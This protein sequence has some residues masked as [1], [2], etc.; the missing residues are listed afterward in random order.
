MAG[1]LRRSSK[2]VKQAKLHFTDSGLAAHLVGASPEA[3]ARP[4]AR[5]AGALLESF[6]A[7]EIA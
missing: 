7:S 2:R 6:V 5:M 1:W 4:H 3:L